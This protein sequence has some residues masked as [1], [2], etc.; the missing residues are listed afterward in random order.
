MI[1]MGEIDVGCRV[2]G[3]QSLASERAR[4]GILS[5]RTGW[6]VPS[7]VLCVSILGSPSYDF[8]HRA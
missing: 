2:H 1:Y 7:M 8:A 5:L 6:S 3:S 4:L